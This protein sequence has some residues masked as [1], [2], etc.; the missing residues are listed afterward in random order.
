M[1]RR[2]EFLFIALVAI[3]MVGCNSAEVPVTSFSYELKQDT[4]VFTNTTVGA[5]SYSWDFGDNSPVSTEKDPV[6]VYKASGSYTVLL[7]ATNEGESKTFSAD[8][9][10]AK[11]LI[12][13]DGDLSD[14]A[15]V[16][17]EKIFT[18]TLPDTATM[19]SI[20]TFKVTFDDNYLYFYVKMDSLNVGSFDI[21]IN[22]DNVSTTGNNSWLWGGICGADYML[23]GLLSANLTDVAVYNFPASTTDQTAWAWVNTVPAGSNVVAISKPKVLSGT[24]V[25]FEG[26]ITKELVSNAW[27]NTIGIGV[28]VQTPSWSIAGCLPGGGGSKVNL[29]EVKLK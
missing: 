6:H 1:K 23:D 11:P 7:T 10:V 16:A 26:K 27:A 5:T 15:S 22:T 3:L 14:W 13:V 2:I 29:L 18:S 9:I 28:F 8:I 24:T 20:Q 17:A 21:F 4:V 19:R 12:K 25:E